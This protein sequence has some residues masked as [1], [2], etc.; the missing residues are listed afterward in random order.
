M[1]LLRRWLISVMF[2]AAVGRAQMPVPVVTHVLHAQKLPY[3]SDLHLTLHAVAPE[4]ILGTGVDGQTIFALIPQDNR[5]WT[6]EMLS[7]WDTSTLNEQSLTFDGNES[8]DKQ[9]YVAGGMTPTPDGKYLL[10]RIFVFHLATLKRDAVVLLVDLRAFRVLWR[11][12]SDDPLLAN[13]RLRFSDEGSLIAAE[14]PATSE[15][16]KRLVVLPEV[17]KMDPYA[18]GE[19]AAAMLSFP[20]LKSSL[21]C[22]YLVSN[23][24]FE[25]SSGHD[26]LLESDSCAELLKS[27]DVA[28]AIDLPGPADGKRRIANLAGGDCDLVILSQEEK[29]AL[30]SCKSGYA[31]S[32][33]AYITKARSVRVLAV[34]AGSDDLSIPL[35][36]NQAVSSTLARANGRDYLIM[37]R[38]GLQLEAYLIP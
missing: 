6:L 9:D 11:R 1:Q 15:G 7:G 8:R 30:Y 23:G 5:R 31:L 24:V 32:K 38:N 34:A 19:H 4:S 35:P 33:N 17:L 13:S 16:G 18:I 36:I 21:Q 20:E 28:T 26:A 37:L 3:V 29:L 25:S 12:V 22:R 27:S 2:L 10:V 14:G